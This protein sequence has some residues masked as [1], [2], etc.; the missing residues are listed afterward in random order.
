MIPRFRGAGSALVIACAAIALGSAPAR[1]QLYL[2][3]LGQLPDAIARS[4]RL[5]GIGR[6]ELVIPDPHNRINLWDYAGNPAG[7]ALDDSASVLYLRPTTASAASVQDFD[8]LIG[9]GERQDFAG[10]GGRIGYEAWRRIPGRSVFGAIGDVEQQRVDQSYTREEEL[11]TTSVHPNIMALVGGRVPYFWSPRFH[12]SLRL[13]SGYQTVNDEYRLVTGNAAGEYIDR[14]GT[15]GSPPNIFT[16]DQTTIETFGAGLAMAYSFGPFLTAAVAGDGVRRKFEGRN[17]GDRYVSERDETRPMGVGQAS[18][19]GRIGRSFQWG[20]DGRIWDSSS[21]ETWVF[22]ISTNAGGAGAPPYAGR[23]DY[24]RHQEHGSTLRAR[25][26]WVSGPLEL[27]A[28]IG[29]SDQRIRLTPADHSYNTFL[30]D[31]FYRDRGDTTVFPDS[32]VYSEREDKAWVAGGGASWRFTKRGAILGAEYHKYEIKRDR[33]LADAKPTV[34]TWTDREEGP[35]PTGWDVRVG[36][37]YP[38]LPVLAARAGYIHRFDDADDLTAQNEQ[39]A[40]SATTGFGLTPAGARWR[41]DASYE[42]QWWQAD[43]GAPT[44]PRG[45]RQLIAAEIGWVF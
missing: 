32:V 24:L 21:T 22:S 16:P 29:S 36:L 8:D 7:L 17:D 35:R 11:R 28:N 4:P 18:L 14:D 1:A 9:A 31:I 42:L 15:L 44:Q 25:A 12:Y 38:L 43:Y 39:I 6:L 23:G 33:T 10:R 27:G 40:N 41:M 26:R 37:E 20:A 2:P 3:S 45:T 19:I 13:V 34:A 30:N 5:V